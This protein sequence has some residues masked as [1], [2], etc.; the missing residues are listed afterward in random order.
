[1]DT[2]LFQGSIRISTIEFKALALF[3]GLESR[4]WQGST[5]LAWFKASMK[6]QC[7]GLIH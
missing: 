2:G 4:P 1:M 3:R 6:V 7:R 5:P